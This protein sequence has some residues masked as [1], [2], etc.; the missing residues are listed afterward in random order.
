MINLLHAANVT[1]ARMLTDFNG[2]IK[3]THTLEEKIKILEWRTDYLLKHNAVLE[4]IILEFVDE[5]TALVNEDKHKK[6]ENHKC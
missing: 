5:V 4:A 6:E 1:T 2:N 3:D